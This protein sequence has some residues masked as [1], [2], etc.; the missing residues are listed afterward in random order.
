MDDPYAATP[1]DRF[2][3]GLWTVGHRGGDPF[4]LPTRPPIAPEEIVARLGEVGAW[5]V[6]LHDEDLVPFG[7]AAAE[8]DGIVSSFARAV[9]GAGMV[10][11]MT[12]VNLFTQPVFRDGA[13]TAADPAVRRFALR[14]T[15]DAIDIG[16]ELGAPTFVL[17][18]G[19]E[20]VESAAARDPRIALERYREGIEF[21]CEY[22]RTQGYETRIALEA[23][24]NEPRG[25]IYLPTTGHMLHFIETLSH[26]S[27]VGVNP[28]VAHEAM[29]GLSFSAA[30][31]QAL[32]AGKLFHIDLNAQNGPRYDQDFRFGAEDLKEAF[33]TV[34][35][36]ERSGY[37]G[38]RHFDARAYRSEDDGDVYSAFAR[39]CI[40]NYKILAAKVAAFDSDPAIT[41]ACEAAGAGQLAEA[42]PAFSAEV[43]AAIRGEDF[44]AVIE[45]R[46]GRHHEAADQLM[47]ELLLGA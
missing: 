25:H 16:A 26:P 3:F 45:G 10:V 37:S 19:R 6:S 20:G 9:S 24:P 46:E 17:W 40:R 44:T 29:A 8:R 28:E 5:G 41:A 27:M 47:V 38:P 35:L 15:T 22:I 36:L 31:G 43:L 12:T 13:F 7:S 23:K 32:W 2:S 33:L 11:S 14:K 30:V 39:G 4:G 1:D 42:T 18:G 21:L 34:R